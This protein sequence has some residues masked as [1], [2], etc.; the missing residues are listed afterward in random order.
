MIN[1]NYDNPQKKD[2]RRTGKTKGKENGGG[3]GTRGITGRG[4][5]EKDRRECL[6]SVD[7]AVHTHRP[8][9]TLLHMHAEFQKLHQLHTPQ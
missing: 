3:K 8:E 1:N 4:E 5:G 7:N 9:I 6:F 2:N